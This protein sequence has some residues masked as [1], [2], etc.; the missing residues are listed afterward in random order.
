MDK[1]L[2][3]RGGSR[4]GVRLLCLC[5]PSLGQGP[6]RRTDC[7]FRLDLN[8][9]GCIIAHQKGR[10]CNPTRGRHVYVLSSRWKNSPRS[11]CELQPRPAVSA[12]S[13]YVSQWRKTVTDPDRGLRFRDPRRISPTTHMAA[14]V[15]QRRANS[16]WVLRRLGGGLNF[17]LTP[18]VCGIAIVQSCQ[19]DRWMEGHLIAVPVAG[20]AYPLITI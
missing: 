18:T 10:L 11:D 7:V 6:A 16:Q 5:L 15:A 17:Y 8:M 4:H 12:G 14:L 3:A 13:R 1:R 9:A 19:I 2:P 20:R